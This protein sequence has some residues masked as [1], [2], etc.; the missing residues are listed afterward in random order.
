MLFA[1]RASRRLVNCTG[2]GFNPNNLVARLTVRTGKV[3]GMVAAH[4]SNMPRMPN[5]REPW[6]ST[7]LVE[8]AA[9]AGTFNIFRVFHRFRA[10]AKRFYAVVNFVSH[11]TA[12]LSTQL[13]AV[14]MLTDYALLLAMLALAKSIFIVPMLVWRRDERDDRPK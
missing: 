5:K 14:D 12:S 7:T 8:S 11:S 10:S 1:H 2:V 6:L 4:L 9:P 3:L 13:Y